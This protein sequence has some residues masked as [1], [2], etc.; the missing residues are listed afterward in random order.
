MAK[1]AKVCVDSTEHFYPCEGGWGYRFVGPRSICGKE[2]RGGVTIEMLM[3][4]G[5][6][7]GSQVM[8]REHVR[9]LH[10][11]LGQWIAAWDA[12]DAQ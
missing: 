10:Q 9:S 11:Q 3:A 4:D 8:K 6:F 12:E 1:K 2:V 7:S 5:K